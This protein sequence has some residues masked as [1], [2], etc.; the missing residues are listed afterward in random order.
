[1]ILQPLTLTA[2]Y[3]IIF[4][5]IFPTRFELPSG[6]SVNYL[7]FLLCGLIPWLTFSTVLV[8][9]PNAITSNA[10]LV[11]NSSFP[12]V[13]FPV[14]EVLAAMITWFVGMSVVI[15][16][17]VALNPSAWPMWPLVTVLLALQAIAMVG[18]SLFLSAVGTFIRD[19]AQL[20]TLIV[21]PLLFVMP[22][23]YSIQSAPPLL[24]PVMYVN[25]FTYMTLAYQDVF[26]YG[27]FAQ[28]IAWIVFALFSAGSLLFGIRTFYRSS[29]MFGSVL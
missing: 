20:M 4:T 5:W 3:S 10:Q 7:L 15:V 8:S 29:P 1:M 24:T 28:P 26:V 23:V 9:S 11:K 17:A 12:L 18:W 14:R 6:A 13:F 16:L 2:V 27:S 21:F 25:P 19:L 22:V